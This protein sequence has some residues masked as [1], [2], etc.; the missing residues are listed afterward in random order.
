MRPGGNAT[1]K[2]PIAVAVVDGNVLVS[3]RGVAEPTTQE[4][5]VTG[6]LGEV[7]VPEPVD[8]HHADAR[9]VGQPEQPLRVARLGHVEHAERAGDGGE[10][11][12]QARVVG[13]RRHEVGR[14]ELGAHARRAVDS[15]VVAG[16]SRSVIGRGRSPR[17]AAGRTPWRR[18]PSRDPPPR[19]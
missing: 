6:A 5:R 12:A 7:G 19:R 4:R 13:A 10:H 1:P 16:A 18:A 11:A 14:L 15:A 8:E 2:V 17:T 9:R 3:G